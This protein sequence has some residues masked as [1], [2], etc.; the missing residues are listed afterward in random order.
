MLE[1]YLIDENKK[2]IAADEEHFN[3]LVIDT[4]DTEEIEQVTRTY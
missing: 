2:V 4:S 3:W 1:Y